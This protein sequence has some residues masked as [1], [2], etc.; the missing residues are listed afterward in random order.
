M[1]NLVVCFLAWCFFIAPTATAATAIQDAPS[2]I[3]QQDEKTKFAR[4]RSKA[5]K[6]MMTG[7]RLIEKGEIDVEQDINEVQEGV[8]LLISTGEG[9]IPKC[10]TSFKRMA[11]ADRIPQL[12]TVL[13]GVLLD[14]DLHLA[15]DLCNK[16]TEAAVYTYLMKRWADSQREDCIEVL[17]KYFGDGSDEVKYHCARGLILRNDLIALDWSIEIIDTQWKSQKQQLRADF[18]G[19]ARGIIDEL[20]AEKIA[21]PNKKV[22][23]HGLHLFELF[24]TKDN[25]HLLKDNLNNSDTALRLGA[26]NACRVVIAGEPPLLRP[27]MT[28]LIELATKWSSEL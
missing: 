10:L 11:A 13:D 6:N 14:S 17:R 23:L 12:C 19:I 27:S 24:G 20:I 25:C 8:D 16:K 28:E 15:L 5:K 1:N 3:E 9:V 2:V 7:L 22:R 21:T 4:L 18:S 26:I